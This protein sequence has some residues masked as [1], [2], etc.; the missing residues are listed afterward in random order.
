MRY[1]DHLLNAVERNPDLSAPIFILHSDHGARIWLKDPDEWPETGYD[2]K[3]FWLDRHAAF[4]A[5]RIPGQPGT[6]ESRPAAV[7]DLYHSLLKSDFTEI[8]NP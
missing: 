1:I 6:R 7:H 8:P 4:F 5:V 3:M 2:E